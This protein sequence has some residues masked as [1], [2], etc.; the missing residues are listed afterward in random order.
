MKTIVKAIAPTAY[1][2]KSLSYFGATKKHLDGSYS[3]EIEFNSKEDAI[4]Y[5]IERATS[6]YDEHEGQVNEHIK[7]I[8]DHGSLEIDAVTGYIEEIE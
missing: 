8:Q 7:R 2:L 4:S 3:V 6:Y 1:Q 5:L